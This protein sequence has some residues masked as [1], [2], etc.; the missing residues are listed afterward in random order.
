MTDEEGELLVRLAR[1]SVEHYIR[2]RSI[3][4][5]PEGIPEKLLRPGMAFVTIETYYGP[6]KRELRGCIGTTA[7][8]KSLARAVVEVAVESAFSDPRFPPLEE[9]ELDNVTFEVSVLSVPEYLG[10][11][12]ESRIQ[13]VLIG[14]DGLIADADYYKGLLLP[15]V[16]VENLWDRSTFLSETCIKAGLWP[17]CW[18]SR[19]VKMY[20]FRARVWREKTPRGPVERRIM[21]EEYINRLARHGVDPGEFEPY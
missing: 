20:R 9:Y 5:L 17:D 21:R 12:V 16:P 18:A 10:D 11:T 7:P 8:V 15:V 6:D 2:Y 13:N 1:E 4:P 14:R 19:R 3:M